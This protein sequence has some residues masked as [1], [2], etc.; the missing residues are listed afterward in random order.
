M[1]I[2]LALITGADIPVPECQ[3]AFHQ[4]SIYEISLIGEEDFFIG[5][6]TLCIS[7]EMISQGETISD[8]ITNFQIF[9]MIMNQRELLE[10]K[11]KAKEVLLM[12]LPKKQ[13]TFTPNSILLMGEPETIIIDEKNFNSFQN[14]LKTIF[15]LSSKASE[16]FN[17]ANG[18]AKKIA[19]KIMRGRQRIAAEKGGTGSVLGQYI[20]SLAVGLHIPVRELTNYT[21]FQLYDQIERFGLYVDWDIDIKSRLAGATPKSSPENWMKDIH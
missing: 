19:D 17:P 14:A 13:I 6:Q 8:E 21:L 16:S 5:V 1:D 20:S 9:M 3:L 18:E 2:R 7:K 15:C 12:V 11:E 4:P 10:K